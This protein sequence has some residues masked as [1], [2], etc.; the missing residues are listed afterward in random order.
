MGLLIAG[1]LPT[2]R[3]VRPTRPAPFDEIADVVEGGSPPSSRSM[4]TSATRLLVL[5]RFSDACVTTL[6]TRADGR[7][8]KSAN[9]MQS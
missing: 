4:L 8:T 2:L 7:R 1:P 3:A 6:S 9:L 5:C